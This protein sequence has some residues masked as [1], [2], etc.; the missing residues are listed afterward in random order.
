MLKSNI[1]LVI[2]VLLNWASTVN[3]QDDTLDINDNIR[4]GFD[5]IQKTGINY[6]NYAE[7]DKINIEVSLWGYVK[8]PGKYLI[9]QGTR[10]IDILT[11]G[12]GPLQDA[13]LEDIRIVRLKNDSLNI[14]KD[15]IIN[16]NYN[17]F[18]WEDQIKTG[19]KDNPVLMP[20]DIILV[21]GEP[22]YFFRENLSI[23]LSISTVLISVGILIIN[24]V[25]K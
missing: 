7:K 25:N 17:D 10:A 22:R 14:S 2:F 20:G 5:E 24:I 11:L 1:A 13:M 21:P 3:A 4:I 23:I 18:L 15:R 19:S 16:L 6:F 12:G 9:P 8:S